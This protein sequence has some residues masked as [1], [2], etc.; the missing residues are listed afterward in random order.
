MESPEYIIWLHSSV[1]IE[2]PKEQSHFPNES[3]VVCKIYLSEKKSEI[4]QQFTGIFYHC[5][6]DMYG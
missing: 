4:L 2:F 1:E 5:T 3:M 6:F